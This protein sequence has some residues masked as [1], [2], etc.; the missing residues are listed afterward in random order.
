MSRDIDGNLL[1]SEKSLLNIHF[2]SVA[3]ARSMLFVLLVLLPRTLSHDYIN[4]CM[5]SPRIE[6]SPKFSKFTDYLNY[7]LN[8][9]VDPCEDFYQFLCG[10]WI[11][12]TND[13]L[14]N[15]EQLSPFR[16]M[17]D[18]Y[19]Q[20]QRKELASREQ[21]KSRAI[22]QARSF[23]NSCVQAEEE[24]NLS[25]VSGV[26]YVMGKIKEFGIFPMLSE[27]PFDEAHFNV[28]FDFTW[29]L[30]YFN[31]ND[32][33]LHII[34]PRIE[35]LRYWT[36]A[37][38]SLHP[39]RS[40]FSFMKNDF[41]RNLQRTFNEFLLRL[42]KLIAA[43][44]GV[45]YYKTNAPPD[46]LDLRI[47]MQKLHA[48][49]MSYGS[50]PTMNL[51][52]VDETVYKVNWTEYL[53]L[54]APPTVH[55]FIA[56][57]PPVLAPSKEYI[58]SLNKVLNETAPRTLTNYV[59]VQYILSWLPRLEKKYRDLLE[60]FIA[61]HDVPQR[62]NR[63]EMCFRLT[64][65]HYRAA[66]LAMYARSIPTEI[67]RPLAE[68]IIRAIINGFK[69]EIKENKWMDKAFK[70][71]VIGKI[72]RITW[73]ILDHDLFHNNTALD[74]LYVA[75]YGLTNQP[76]LDMLE[77][78]THIRKTETFLK[79]ITETVEPVWEQYGGYKFGVNAYYN[80]F[81]N[82]I[83]IPLPIL[84]FPIFD[85]SFPRS[86]LYGSVGHIIGHEIS[87]SLDVTG[88]NYDGNGKKRVWW[89]NEWTKEYDKRTHC[90][91]KQYDNVKI[92]LFNISLNGTLY[93]GEN[94]ADNEGIK[95]AHRAFK[96]Y[97]AKLEGGLKSEHVDGFTQDQLFILGS[98]QAWCR[99]RAEFTMYAELD[100]GDPHPPSEYRVDIVL[101]NFAPFANAFHCSP[102]AGMNPKHR[103]SIW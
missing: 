18:L 97:L 9:K 96:K 50:S 81:T 55:S 51:S 12:N 20:K 70:K 32:T 78:I 57:D 71:A 43:D 61:N 67:I 40:L 60:W 19:E 56:E 75:H 45:N 88:R 35:S 17:S 22:M 8:Y 65:E 4:P 24:W 42:M 63:S 89:K 38:I 86:Y 95:I 39:E 47:F 29:L 98:S 2:T 103:C 10:N 85:E 31:H 69:E 87:H 54:T 68:T 11:A 41:T 5:D 48:I 80:P 76:F 64:N 46:I 77:K 7:S 59:M 100:G 83:E 53:L 84:Q 82:N 37:K 6:D 99:K 94:I 49:P 92:P 26:K 15:W 34:V 36:K 74:E 93:L 101:K 21:S 90:F 23:Y 91:V 1:S 33:V 62:L 102:K 58:E 72:S 14:M 52:E 13:T 28:N 66:V 16:Q 3:A 25:G 30:A 27:E 73:I 44:T 79:L